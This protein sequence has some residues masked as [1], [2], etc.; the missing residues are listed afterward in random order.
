MNSFVRTQELTSQVIDITDVTTDHD[1]RQD[2]LDRL[3]QWGEQNQL[4]RTIVMTSNRASAPDR[5]DLL[6]DYDV[7]LYVSDTGY[8]GETEDWLSGL[9]SV[10]IRTA[11]EK[12]E[13]HGTTA[14]WRG[15]F[16]DDM[17]KVDFTITQSDTLALIRNEPELPDVFDLGYL[18][19]IDKDNLT[20]GLKAPTFK[21]FIPRKPT[22]SEYRTLVENFWWCATYAAKYLWRDQFFAAKLI[23]DTE[24]RQL[25]LQPMLEW[26]IEIKNDWTVQLGAFGRQFRKYLTPDMWVAVEKVFA[27]ADK[28]DNWRALFAMT[29]VF[30]AAAEIVA[31]SLGYEYP[32]DIDARMTSYVRWI[33]DLP[34]N[35][36]DNR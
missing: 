3:I 2:F 6:S 21:A 20:S 13:N 22:E 28:E 16:F 31:R 10:L 34:P 14:Y 27:G 17:T 35:H 36:T 8:F 30:R 25:V 1:A 33:R 24:M 5:V 15:V 19:L 18:V 29:E 4:V 26:M 11:L 23:L 7:I 12:S 32:R 9:G